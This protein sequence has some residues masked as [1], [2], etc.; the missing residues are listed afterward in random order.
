MALIQCPECKKEISSKAPTCPHCGAPVGVSQT[1]EAVT[2][3]QETSKSLKLQQLGASFLIL[4]GMVGCLMGSNQMPPDEMNGGILMFL[5]GSVW[6]IVVRF[7]TWWKH[8]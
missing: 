2:T 4:A 8:G 1:S 7:S 5:A 3:I 6:L